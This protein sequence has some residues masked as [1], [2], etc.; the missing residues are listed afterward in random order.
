MLCLARR[1]CEPNR[2]AEQ[3]LCFNPHDVEYASENISR[4]FCEKIVEN[5]RRGQSRDRLEVV[6]TPLSNGAALVSSS[7][8]GKG[9]RLISGKY[10]P[11]ASS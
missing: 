11:K 5:T 4:R 2:P 9:Y 7:K 1:C 3:S 10:F 8:T 6:S